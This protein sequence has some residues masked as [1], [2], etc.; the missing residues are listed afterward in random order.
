MATACNDLPASA[1]LPQVCRR[2]LTGAKR[3]VVVLTVESR[4]T[5]TGA[6]Y[7]RVLDDQRKEVQWTYALRRRLAPA[8]A[9]TP[10]ASVA[11]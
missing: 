5:S 4:A 3:L 6:P 1:R 9:S 2:R 8:E 7:G 10:N 11:D